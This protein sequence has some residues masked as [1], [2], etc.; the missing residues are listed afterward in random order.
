MLAAAAIGDVTATSI[1]VVLVLTLQKAIEALAALLKKK[2]ASCS[3][4]VDKASFDLHAQNVERML[5]EDPPRKHTELL[6]DVARA[7]SQLH[8]GQER[9]NRAL[10]KICLRLEAKDRT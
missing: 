5:N 4:G 3:H 6:Q 7:L 10:E 1:V 2:S 9:T 8:E